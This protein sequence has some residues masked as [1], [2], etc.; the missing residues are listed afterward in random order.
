[1]MGFA[2]S[3]A[4][5]FLTAWIVY[6]A[7]RRA[8]YLEGIMDA[9]RQWRRELD[10]AHSDDPRIRYIAARFNAGRVPAGTPLPCGC[11][12]ICTDQRPG[13]PSTAAELRAHVDRDDRI[14]GRNG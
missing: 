7:T 2:V 12:D 9:N 5:V 13:H 11:L 3:T 4:A 6:A 8:A 1:M 14:Y 10:D